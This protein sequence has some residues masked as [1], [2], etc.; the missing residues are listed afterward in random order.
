MIFLIDILVFHPKLCP[1]MLKE[2]M[3][4]KSLIY[5]L[6]AHALFIKL[7]SLAE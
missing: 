6:T 4:Q 1:K 2:K 3:M 7:D 5:I